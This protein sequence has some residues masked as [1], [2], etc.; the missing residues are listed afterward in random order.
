MTVKTAESALRGTYAKTAAIREGILT[1]CID[2]FGEVGFYG[3]TMKDV[4]KRSGISHSGLLHHFARKE[5]LLLALLELR[6]A[7]SAELLNDAG[8]RDPGSDPL[9]VLR[10]MMRVVAENELQPG[11]MELHCVIMGEATSP[12]HPAHDYYAQRSR[13]IRSYYARAFQALRNDGA[14]D[15]EID[16]DTLGV[17]ALALINGVQAQWLLDRNSVRVETVISEF[18]SSIVPSFS[19]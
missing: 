11:L 13:Y 17:M 15:S 16:A 3:T 8:V 9:G 18:L 5:D 7:R 10:G 4:A 2:S 6:A 14:L 1:A 12:H 19:V